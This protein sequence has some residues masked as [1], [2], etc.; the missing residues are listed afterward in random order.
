MEGLGIR[1]TG[2]DLGSG[3]LAGIA[4]SNPAPS[5]LRFNHD[6]KPSRQGSAMAE[7]KRPEKYKPT[8]PD[9]DVVEKLDPEH[10]DEDFFSDLEKATSDEARRKLGLP[11][12]PDRGSERTS[13]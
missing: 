4:G 1:R 2:P 3:M 12:A 5:A 6:C 8:P 13:E 7:R 11:S 10:S 9:E